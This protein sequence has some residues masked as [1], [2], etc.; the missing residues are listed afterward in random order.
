MSFDLMAAP[1]EASKVAPN[2]IAA[3]WTTS[4]VTGS[5]EP[6][7][8]YEAVVAFP[9]LTFKAVVLVT[10][11]PGIDRLFVGQQSGEIY[12][13]PLE[14][15]T[16][17]KEMFANFKDHDKDRGYG[18]V[19]VYGLA[20]HPQ[21][22]SNDRVYVC[23]IRGG[24]EE[25]GSVVSEFVLSQ[26]D[27][28]VLNM[29]SEREL[30]TWV[31]GGHNGGCIKFGPKDG[32]LYITTGD[33]T[34]P[35]PPDGLHTGQD[36]TDLLSSVLRI[37]IDTTEGG[38]G[39][40]IPSDNPFIGMEGNRPEIWSFGFRN[41]W[42]ISFDPVN[43][44]LWLGD[45]GWELWE[46]I[47]LVE[48]GGN[49]G[50]S[51]MEGNQPVRPDGDRGPTPILP[52]TVA[53][54]HTEA[55]S[56]TGGLVYYGSRL[57]DLV[58][59]YVYG[60]YET[61]KFWGLRY[62]HEEKRV[63]WNEEIAQSAVRIVGFGVDQHGEMY[64]GDHGTGQ[65]YEL[66]P[67]RVGGGDGN[68]PRELSKA[69]LF[70][71]TAPLQPAPGV[72]PY[73][74][75]V[76][77][78]A[79]HASSQR[80]IAVPGD[81]P[82]N[83]TGE[84]G[85]IFPEGTVLAKTFSLEME[86]GKPA[87]RRPVETQLLH[88]EH[89]NWNAYSYAWNE[90]GTDATLV[91]RRGMERA[92]TIR[93]P[94]GT[95]RQQT[96]RYHSRA[97]CILCHNRFSNFILGMTAS[98]AG[99][100]RDFGAGRVNQLDAL[101]EV[102]AVSGAPTNLTPLPDAWDVSNSLEDRARAYLHSNCAHCHRRNGGGNA[103]I[104]LPF[105]HTLAE[106]RAVGE[107]AQLGVFGLVGSEV[108]SP[109][110]PSR[111]VLF[112]RVNALGGARMPRLGTR[113]VDQRGVNLLRDWIEQLPSVESVQK[114]ETKKR[115]SVLAAEAATAWRGNYDEALQ[116]F[117]AADTL[118]ER[119][120]AVDE[121]FETSNGALAILAAIERGEYRD[122]RAE[123]LVDKGIAHPS[124]YI[125][126]LYIRFV[127]EEQREKKLGTA[128]E[129][130]QI[131]ALQGDANRG[132]DLFFGD[133]V[134]QCKN[135]HTV[136]DSKEML[137]P[138][139]G[140]IAKKYKRAE[141]LESIIEPSKKIEPQFVVYVAVTSTGEIHTGM[142][143]EKNEKVVVLKDNKN[144]R[145]TIDAKVVQALSPQ[146]TSLMPDLLLRDMTA[147]QVADLLEFLMSSAREDTQS[148]D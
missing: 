54:S 112:Y 72:Y 133:S 10:S 29:E 11:A 126:A 73:S 63:S 106:T 59:T 48:R 139:L 78:W 125:R 102:G 25:E 17:T 49:F 101:A 4:R 24:P 90:E 117:S 6:P 47:D 109:G 62:D 140:Q 68:F 27:P 44:D 83:V 60:D 122:K 148:G 97:E 110:D 67:N 81:Q 146:P 86:V 39:Y 31:R 23:Y 135:C 34:S 77:P 22:E 52:P 137:G 20:F 1:D 41:P 99:V 94:G 69:G 64:I 61:G 43:G 104:E 14:R 134:A 76:E 74:V 132:R 129:P 66:R 56:I 80:H 119:E 32:Y 40:A 84:S 26:R 85:W 8:P 45:V 128:F 55:R 19:G 9:N 5:P 124:S 130:A 144:Q 18:G 57:K 28:P 75:A 98:Q 88:Y 105:G 35:F 58:G 13:F 96:W 91:D 114:D 33:A 131:L 30:I 142:L 71:S 92:L 95:T 108:L 65:I 38:R 42:K 79:D 15:A 138:D 136:H 120:S 87:S 36:N 51:V 12:S 7:P 37:D 93:D 53:H 145:V 46:M 123:Q 70:H 121:L 89:K 103:A 50:W 147:Q 107:R 100:Q 111:S 115:Q 16:R 2:L 113:V 116:R 3:E 143:A 118:A 127:P 141:I 82:V 21:F